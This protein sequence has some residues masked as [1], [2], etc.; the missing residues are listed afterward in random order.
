[1]ALT[2]KFYFMEQILVSPVPQQASKFSDIYFI[3]QTL[4]NY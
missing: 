1:M 2:L 4:V 3:L